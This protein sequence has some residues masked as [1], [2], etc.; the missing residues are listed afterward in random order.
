MQAAAGVAARRAILL[1]IPEEKYLL[2]HPTA[3]ASNYPTVNVLPPTG[4][5]GSDLGTLVLTLPIAL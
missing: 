3:G 5:L 1:D 4:R 2:S